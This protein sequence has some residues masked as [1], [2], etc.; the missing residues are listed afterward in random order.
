M[1][2]PDPASIQSNIL[3]GLPPLDFPVPPLPLITAIATALSVGWTAWASTLLLAGNTVTGSGIGAWA[4][5][6]G[7]G[8][9]TGSP[10][11]MATVPPF[12]APATLLLCG[13]IDTEINTELALWETTYVIAS[14]AY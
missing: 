6:G 4:G 7:G 9:F 14:M 1:P 10:M 3:A 2:V 13:E 11:A 12:P 8:M 5:S